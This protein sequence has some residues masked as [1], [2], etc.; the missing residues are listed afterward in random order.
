MALNILLLAIPPALVLMGLGSS[1]ITIISSAVLATLAAM[2]IA[3]YR[4]SQ[5]WLFAA[6][7]ALMWAAREIIGAVPGFG[8]SNG[9]LAAE[10]MYFLA[11]A[12]WLIALIKMQP[13]LP[14]SR[15][16]LFAMPLVFFA[17]W[18]SW[19]SWLFK[20]NI[21]LLPELLLAL[22]SLALACES[23]AG[24]AHEGR[25]IWAGG[26][27]IRLIATAVLVFLGPQSPSQVIFLIFA[28]SYGLIA[29]GAF[30]ELS[31]SER[32]LLALS[33]SLISLELFIALIYIIFNKF[34][35]SL[36]GISRPTFLAISYL[37]PIVVLAIVLADRKRR[38]KAE[39]QLKNYSDLLEHI[40]SYKSV[41]TPSPFKLDGLEQ[42]LFKITK[43]SFPSLTGLKIIRENGKESI[44]GQTDATSILIKAD[45]EVVGS[46][47]LADN[48]K[49]LDLI[50]NIAPL[51]GNYIKT[52]LGHYT[53]R[54]E[55]MT[56]PL[57][58]VLNRRGF[59]SQS[60]L[61]LKEAAKHQLPISLVLIDI[62][63]FKAINDDYGHQIGDYVLSTFSKVVNRNIRAFDLFARWGGEEFLIIFYDADIEKTKLIIDRIYQDL[64]RTEFEYLSAPPSFSA[65]ISGG[66]VPKS[67]SLDDLLAKA[68]QAMY[69]AK[70]TGRNKHVVLN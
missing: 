36:S 64:N 24:N 23:V 42:D 57:T 22:I 43:A 28:L 47:Y 45:D 46:L 20:A 15:C 8:D 56:D 48:V 44:F 13:G 39:T 7:G 19:Q 10:I 1:Q 4:N 25:I 32:N 69:I 68:D 11:A 67:L 30:L 66:E 54:T 58:K 70:K 29:V 63:H 38:S 59:E 65:G 2:V 52:T 41:E 6:I 55:A 61:L 37:L 9:I 51:L 17:L 21:A 14:K 62:D 50:K 60:K 18:L 5:A 12:F 31:G 33:Q 49:N 27:Y 26:F 53:T 16:L 35:S 3:R 40:L 34:R